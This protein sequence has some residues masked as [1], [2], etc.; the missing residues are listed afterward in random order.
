MT[1]S[2]AGAVTLTSGG[3]NTS[4]TYSGVAS[5][6]SGTLSM[7][8]TGGTLILTLS[9]INTYTGPTTINGGTISIAADSGLGA[10]PASATPGQL[11][12]NSGTLVVTVITTLSPNRG[13][14]LT[15]P[16]TISNAVAVTYGGIIAGAGTLTKLGAGTLT[17]SG[18]NTYT[19]ATFINAGTISIA[20]DSGLGTAPGSATAGQLTFNGGT[21]LAS[22]TLTLDANRGI[23]LT[24]AGTF[25]PSTGT[26]LTYGGIIA[27]AS[28]LTQAGAGT[29][30]P[31]GGQ[32]LH[33]GDVHQRRHPLDRRRQRPR[34]GAG[35]GNGRQADLQR[36]HPARDRHHDPRLDPRHR[37]HRHRRRSRPTPASP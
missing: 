7:T 15:G 11:T 30:R 14:A 12:L 16:G 37:P 25:S 27:G 19:G 34:R 2:V 5:D 23:A 31:L 35:R 1:S 26:T 36:R 20:A 3:N 8:K 13:I 6:G 21:L 28:T 22:A 29:A 33:R 9:G 24:G 18:I 32:H 4:T 17:L 10:A